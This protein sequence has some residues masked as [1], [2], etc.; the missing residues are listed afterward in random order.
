MNNPES[1]LSIKPGDVFNP[2][3]IFVGIFIPLPVVRNPNLTAGAK[4]CYGQLCLHAGEKGDCYPSQKLLAEELGL[5]DRHIRNLLEE[6]VN[7]GFLVCKNPSGEDRLKH[8]NNQYFFTWHPSFYSPSDNPRPELHFRSGKEMEFRSKVKDNSVKDQLT[9]KLIPSELDLTVNTHPNSGVENNVVSNFP[10]PLYLKKRIKDIPDVDNKPRQRYP[11]DFLDIVNYWNNSLGLPK[12][13]TPEIT[14]LGFGEPTKKF[15][16]IS[17]IVQKVL[18]GNYFQTFGI[19]GEENKPYSK[20]EIIQAIDKYKLTAVNPLYLPVDKTHFKNIDLGSFFY[21]SWSGHV[22]SWFLKSL[23][24][25]PRLV[26]STI[27]LQQNNNPQLTEWLMEIYREKIL[28]GQKIDFP[29]AD[30]NKFTSGANQLQL[31]IRNL[32]RRMNMMTRP[33]EW[34]NFVIDS[35]IDKWGKEEIQIGHI[36]SQYTYSNIL[37][38][39]LRKKGRIG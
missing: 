2:R 37:V 20:E 19:N 28:S 29:P 36:S 12:L 27:P 11:K 35:L 39:Y 24:E 38:K 22:P 18:Q 8:L 26:R 30:I 34:C 7:E 21:N 32:H 10:I 9:D 33:I 14:N 5:S 6:L 25:E 23:K 13:V 15:I 17:V 16:R 1:D 3:R 4:L 31:T